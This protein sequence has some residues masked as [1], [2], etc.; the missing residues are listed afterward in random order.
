MGL[1]ATREISCTTSNAR[2]GSLYATGIVPANMPESCLTYCINV[3]SYKDIKQ[4]CQ[5]PDLLSCSYE[6][7]NN[8]TTA[9][10]TNANGYYTTL[11][12]YYD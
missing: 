7:I 11:A 1:N 3:D 10:T 5:V 9:N 4:E 8:Y 12:Q 2:L 6:T